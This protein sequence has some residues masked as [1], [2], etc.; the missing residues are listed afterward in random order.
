MA[1]LRW[2]LA[3]V[4][5]LC[6][7]SEAAFAQALES[8]RQKIIN[9]IG[10]QVNFGPHELDIF[11]RQ[12]LVILRGKV[13]SERDKDLV[14]QIA[15]NQSGVTRVRNELKVVPGGLY[16]PPAALAARVR[17]NLL[18]SSGV[19][20]L[21]LSVGVSGDTVR[22]SGEA[23]NPQEKEAIEKIVLNTAG[24]KRVRNELSIAAPALADE[25]IARDIRAA[26]AA[27]PEINERGLQV[28]VKNGVATVRGA[29]NNHRET[30]R[31][32]SVALMVP[33]VKDIR[34]EIRQVN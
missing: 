12:E 21:N 2:G 4:L 7:V 13:S 20:S 11:A 29:T 10:N 31:I 1:S 3:F 34:S 27:N 8:T 6:G 28:E 15:R 23:A 9:E 30:D 24:V 25:A 26:F 32:L 5:V 14:E 19:R 33:G 18:A 17:E 16:E 22:L